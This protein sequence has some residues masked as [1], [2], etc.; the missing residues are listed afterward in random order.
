MRLDDEFG[1][2]DLPGCGSRVD[3][4]IAARDDLA[5]YPIGNERHGQ[6]GIS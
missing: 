6:I 2:D 5:S 3:N 1:H 4:S